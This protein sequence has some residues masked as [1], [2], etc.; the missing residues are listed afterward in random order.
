MDN[1]DRQDWSSSDVKWK[2]VWILAFGVAVATFL[3][4][5]PVHGA[6][7]GV[8]GVLGGL[9]TS[10]TNGRANVI[11]Q[12]QLASILDA[13][14]DGAVKQITVAAPTGGG[15][16]ITYSVQP[17]SSFEVAGH[18]CRTFTIR[19]AAVETIRESFRIACKREDGTWRVGAR[20][21]TGMGS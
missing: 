13:A 4:Y 6:Q 11:A 2:H 3:A 21:E 14:E 19:A 12:P 9:F 5:K 1:Q 18:S 8:V 16:P 7:D 10:D 20:P 15:K 17:R